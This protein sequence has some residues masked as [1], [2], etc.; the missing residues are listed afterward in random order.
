MARDQAMSLGLSLVLGTIVFLLGTCMVQAFV[1]APPPPLIME[2][3]CQQASVIDLEGTN[4]EGR[5]N[6]CPLDDGISLAMEAEHLVVGH[7]YTVWLGYFDL[8]V[9]CQWNPCGLGD[10]LGDDP[11]GVLG[12]MDG[13]VADRSTETFW[14]DFHGLRFSATR[15]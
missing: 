1:R 11:V 7:T 14:G 6:L 13:R 15:V 3:G 9:N 8:P 4:I 5:A 12:R 10:V 2:A